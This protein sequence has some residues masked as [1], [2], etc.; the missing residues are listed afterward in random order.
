[1]TRADVR[2]AQQAGPVEPVL[3]VHEIQGDSLAGFRKDQ[4]DFI[5]LAIDDVALA[6]A[7]LLE[8]VPR[9]SPLG[10]VATFN[11][12]FRSLRRRRG[13]LPGT[14][15]VTWVNVAFSAT[16][17]TKLSSAQQVAQLAD[18]PFKK[19]L[20][21]RSGGLGDPNDPSAPGHPR[22]WLFGGPSKPVD[23]VLLVAADDLA[24]LEQTSAAV[25]EGLTTSPPGSSAAGFRVVYAERGAT[26]RDL[27]GHEHFGFRDGVSQP[28]PRGRIG[29]AEFLSP[30]LIDPADPRALRFARAGQPLVWPGEFVLGLERQA[31]PP[32]DDLVAIPPQPPAPAWA[33]NG[34]Y[35]VIRRLRQDVATFRRFAQETAAELAG[36]PPFAG[37]SPERLQALLVGRWPSGAPLTRAPQADDPGLGADAF[38]ANDFAY[39]NAHPPCPLRPEI[40][41]AADTF[42]PALADPGG[43]ICPRGAHVR[44]VNPRDQGT[45]VGG[46][47]ATLRRLVLRR[48]MPFGDP[49]QQGT[50]TGERGLMFACY[51]AS[52]RDQ[53]EFLSSSWANSS[54]NPPAHP[55]QDLIIGQSQSPS[56]GRRR[57]IFLTAPDGSQH[58]LTTD[59]EWV[60]AT[61]GGY[62][63]APSI[64]A[65]RDTLT[66]A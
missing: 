29:A 30:R 49:Y 63:F 40:D 19:G 44:K 11:H 54:V 61:G 5:F 25:L 36:T 2:P 32:D 47:R 43:T 56:G 18:E 13:E 31:I 33:R 34:S 48:G 1:M 22:N 66:A 59:A 17:L 38:A 37:L 12:L 58:T 52:I 55:G 28:A 24:S 26:R 60:L 20:A 39:V 64:S 35:L 65:L 9:I 23:A 41:H 42:A 10:D 46:P 53:F 21:A 6:K 62:F 57:Q 4:Q 15:A 27:P 51:Q 45:D 3:D 16:G 7:A 8:L 14:L 50:E